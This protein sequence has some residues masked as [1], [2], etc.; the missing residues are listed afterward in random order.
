M[1]SGKTLKWLAPVPALCLAASLYGQTAY[2]IG[3]ETGLIRS[4]Y[5]YS[6]NGSTGRIAT[7]SD[8][9]VGFRIGMVRNRFVSEAGIGG[10][11]NQTPCFVPGATGNP[12]VRMTNGAMHI[13]LRSYSV[14]VGYRYLFFANRLNIT[15][16]MGF[17]VLHSLNGRHNISLW[18]DGPVS[19][20]QLITGNIPHD[21]G[22]TIANGHRPGNYIVN[23]NSGVEASYSIHPMLQFSL[24]I[25]GIMPLAPVFYEHITQF[26]QAEPI[27]ATTAQTGPLALFNVGIRLVLPARVT[28][29]TESDN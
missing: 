4:R 10:L 22:V 13:D 15:P 19:L 23:L 5:F 28:P 27:A 9:F 17:G 2:Q 25:T 6:S 24:G 14:S 8:G 1:G 11:S 18:T 20:E 21:P 3:L 16:K 29:K 26:T 7:V 12:P